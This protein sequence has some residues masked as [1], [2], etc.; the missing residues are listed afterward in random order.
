M[1]RSTNH[2]SSSLSGGLN[3]SSTS[4]TSGGAGA[5][6]SSFFSSP[7]SAS[8]TSTPHRAAS[9][10]GLASSSHSWLPHLLPVQAL[11]DT[12]ADELKL[13][14]EVAEEVNENSDLDAA[15]EDRKM[16]LAFNCHR[17]VDDILGPMPG[18][19]SSQ[20]WRNRCVVNNHH[21]KACLFM[22][23]NQA[24][25]IYNKYYAIPISSAAHCRLYLYLTYKR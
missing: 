24:F 18:E 4:A 25:P 8:S 1:L 19:R 23:Q 15:A 16:P 13:E 7:H 11:E 2:S 5:A 21:L 9:S 6:T 10:G 20:T 14:P 22:P 17:H 12:L 3:T